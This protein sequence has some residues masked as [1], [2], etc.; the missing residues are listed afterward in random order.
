[1]D[2]DGDEDA[3]EDEDE[4]DDDD[5]DDYDDDDDDDG[6]TPNTSFVKFVKTQRWNVSEHIRETLPFNSHISKKVPCLVTVPCCGKKTS[7][8][9]FNKTIMNK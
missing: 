8:Y 1:M 7:V 6:T 2:K 4:D 9:V 3:D 5:V